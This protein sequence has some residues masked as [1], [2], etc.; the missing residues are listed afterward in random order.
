MRRPHGVSLCHISSQLDELHSSS[1]LIMS[2]T[3]AVA[4]CCQLKLP[5]SRY[6]LYHLSGRL[7]IPDDG[8]AD[9]SCCIHRPRLLDAVAVAGYV[10]PS[11]KG[12]NATQCIG[13]TY[14]PNLNKL[15]G[16]LKCQSGLK[17]PV[18]YSGPR[19]DKTAVCRE[20]HQ[21]MMILMLLQSVIKP[22]SCYYHAV[23][24]HRVVASYRPDPTI[25]CKCCG[26]MAQMPWCNNGTVRA[27][28]VCVRCIITA[29][30]RRQYTQLTAVHPFLA[31][32][33]PLIC[34]CCRC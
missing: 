6:Y 23:A 10:L 2:Y 4:V 16:C 8:S 14:A 5:G 30:N 1:S 18:G 25:I 32:L 27:S 11:T 24:C 17:A 12:G 3:A 13:D 34:C 21:H 28:P 20:Y 15:S 33:L 7:P 29:V 26:E 22:N 31:C 9:L 19:N